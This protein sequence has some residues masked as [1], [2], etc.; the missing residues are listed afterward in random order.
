MRVSKIV[1]LYLFILLLTPWIL[2][3]V[4][5]N[6][7]INQKNTPLPFK[8]NQKISME[9]FEK[10]KF[11]LKNNYSPP[12]TVGYG[13]KNTNYFFDLVKKYKF[14]P[15]G[16]FPNKKTYFCD[17]GYGFIHFKTDHLGLRN[18][19]EEWSK[20][21]PYNTLIIGDSFVHGAC[22]ENNKDISSILRKNGRQVINLGLGDNQPIQYF[23]LIEKFAKPKAPR[24]LVLVFYQGNDFSYSKYQDFYLKYNETNGIKFSKKDGFHVLGTSAKKL[25]KELSYFNKIEINEYIKKGKN[26]QK[27]YSNEIK[28]RIKLSKI[29]EILEFKYSIIIKKRLLCY[30]ENCLIGSIDELFV[31]VKLAISSLIKNCNPE[32]KCNPVVALIPNSTLWKPGKIHETKKN[33]FDKIVSNIIKDNNFLVYYDSSKYIDRN[34]LRNYAP[35]GGHFS[36]EGYELFATNLEKY[37]K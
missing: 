35:A 13:I 37:L 16:S 10:I 3:I 1:V 17:E 4:I 6:L 20:N 32:K 15:V 21:Y 28:N 26:E 19:K 9:R 14:I 12:Y 2:E 18:P 25:Y 5:S 33:Y 23:Y 8:K 30:K 24:N 36:N 34:N 7:Q 27:N 11:F 22:V 31:D 29:R